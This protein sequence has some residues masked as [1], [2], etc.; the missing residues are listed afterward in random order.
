MFGVIIEYIKMDVLSTALYVYMLNVV[1]ALICIIYT[2]WH[3][4][5]V[6]SDEE[7]NTRILAPKTPA[8]LPSRSDDHITDVS[9]T[10]DLD[11]FTVS[12]IEPLASDDSMDLFEDI[13]FPYSQKPDRRHSQE[14]SLSPG[15][16]PAKRK[17]GDSQTV[18]STSRDQ[19]TKLSRTTELQSTAE[20]KPNTPFNQSANCSDE[21]CSSAGPMPA[22]SKKKI[23]QA[24][25]KNNNVT[26]HRVKNTTQK[27][28]P[29]CSK[30]HKKTSPASMASESPKSN[31]SQVS[32]PLHTL[33][34]AESQAQDANNT[35]EKVVSSENQDRS[36][37]ME[38][39][40]DSESQD[41]DSALEEVKSDSESQHGHL[42]GDYNA[43]N[44]VYKPI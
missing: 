28:G 29:R 24:E 25:E 40:V 22:T 43:H 10:L 19:P 14:G 18:S 44:N 12:Q 36:I 27:P 3:R 41:D 37:T 38:T 32:S 2:G 39:P 5:S 23:C 20:G 15:R 16:S 21:P 33:S 7:A 34:D 31:D 6:S 1:I 30:I 13:L 42:A 17:R 35:C 8:I 4:D 26:K 9:S 11:T